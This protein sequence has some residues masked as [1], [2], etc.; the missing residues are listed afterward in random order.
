[1]ARVALCCIC[2]MENEYIREYVQYYKDLG[3]AKIFLYD[4]ND[5][6]GEVLSEPIQDF[7]DEGFVEI[8]DF[9]GLKLCQFKAYD[10]CYNKN[11]KEFDWIAFFDADEFLTFAEDDMTLEKWI[12]DERFSDTSIIHINW[13]V[14]DNNGQLFKREGG[15]Q[16][17]FTRPMLPLNRCAQYGNIPENNH[18]KS[19]VRGGLGNI[20]WINPH[21]LL[22]YSIPCKKAN[23]EVGDSNSSFEPY[24]FSVA[25]LKHYRTKSLEEYIRKL[26][27]RGYPDIIIKNEDKQLHNILVKFEKYN[28]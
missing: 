26:V 5:I 8:I 17:R 3:V 1:M 13:L 16:E 12:S 2:K 10:D 28:G 20:R 25:Y 24:D 9:R 18:I 11:N 23:Y 7:I 15:V 6:D 4:N 27:I 14:Y 19:I 21:S 22:G